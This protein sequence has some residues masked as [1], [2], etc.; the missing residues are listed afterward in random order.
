VHAGLD[1]D[2]SKIAAWPCPTPT[3]SNAMP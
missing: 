2:A 1:H 3:H